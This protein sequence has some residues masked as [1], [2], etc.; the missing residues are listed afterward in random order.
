MIFDPSHWPLVKRLQADKEALMTE[1]LEYQNLVLDKVNMTT[2]VG[3]R[4]LFTKPMGILAYTF[5]PT[6]WTPEERVNAGVLSLER[7]WPAYSPPVGV[8]IARDFPAIRQF[9]WN[10][11]SPGGKVNPHWGINGVLQKRVPDHWRIQICW[12]PGEQAEFHLANE[13]LKYTED[14]CFGFND[15]LDLH[16]AHNNGETART[17]IIIDVHR[18]QVPN[19]DVAHPAA[20][21][22]T[23]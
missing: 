20:I 8:K 7:R 22:K 12:F 5:D 13:Y 15:G 9:Y 10:V 19:A 23:R 11:L 1:F 18:D 16:W 4:P 3:N 6:L 21:R 2:P 14:L 17:T